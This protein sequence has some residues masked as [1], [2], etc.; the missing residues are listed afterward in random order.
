MVK[1][2]IRKYKEVKLYNNGSGIDRSYR[3][4]L[5]KVFQYEYAMYSLVSELFAHTECRSMCVES[6]K[7]YFQELP[8]DGSMTWKSVLAEMENLVRQDSRHQSS[9]RRYTLIY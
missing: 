2:M 7:L 1:N 4:P 6:L 5:T 8:D 9:S 3:N